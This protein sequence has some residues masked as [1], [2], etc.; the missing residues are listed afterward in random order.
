MTRTKLEALL[1]PLQGPQKDEKVVEHLRY[2]RGRGEG[3]GTQGPPSHKESRRSGLALT[4]GKSSQ[5]KGSL[6]PAHLKPI[7][8]R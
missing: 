3:R 4:G 2:Q 7:T 5:E 6:V 1:Y 8:P